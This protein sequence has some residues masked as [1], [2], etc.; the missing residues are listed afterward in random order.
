MHLRHR[1]PVPGD[2]EEPDEA[3]VARFDRSFERTAVAQ[4][5]LPLVRVDEVVQ[6]EE[7]DFLDAETLER[8]TELVAR[9]RVLTLARLRRKEEVVAVLR[10][11]RRE[12]Q[13][14]IA[15]RRSG[16]DVVDTV[17]E[18]HVEVERRICFRLRKRAERGRTEDRARALV[19]RSAECGC[20][21]Q[22][23]ALDAF[24]ATA[25]RT[26]LFSASPSIASPSRKSMARRVFPSRLELNSPAGSSSAAP[27][28]NV[29][30]TT[31]LYVSPVQ[32]IPSCS[33]TGTPRHFH[34]STTSG[35]AS[36]TSARSRRSVSPRQSSSSSILPSIS[37]EGDLSGVP[38]IPVQ[39]TGR[40]S[41]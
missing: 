10:E 33:H 31:L 19:A 15:V 39:G 30:F 21:N 14:G 22:R 20:R 12:A 17:L 7:V 28:A 24:S 36:F 3:F 11:P 27:F 26:R 25:A 40:R 35:S 23:R 37:W 6:L 41:V 13:L 18:Q 1:Q 8:A 16:V 2:A 4:R 9:R 38:G 29:I 5:D 32:M 34:S